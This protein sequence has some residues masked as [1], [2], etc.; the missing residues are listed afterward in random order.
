[1]NPI[2]KREEK[3][4][5]PT[6]LKDTVISNEGELRIMLKNFQPQVE[7]QARKTL[8]EAFEKL[9]TKQEARKQIDEVKNDDPEIY[10]GFEPAPLLINDASYTLD[11]FIRKRMGG[12]REGLTIVWYV[13]GVKWVFD[14]WNGR[15]TSNS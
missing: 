15:L 14:P 11:T 1:M 2:R 12:E 6:I 5:K 4:Q 7:S 3:R 9:K 13:Q 8:M 10:G